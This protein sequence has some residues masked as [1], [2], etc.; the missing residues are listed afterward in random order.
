[1]L[2]HE[3]LEQ[4]NFSKTEQTV[5]AF[6][7][8]HEDDL[9]HFTTTK[10]AAATFTTPSILVRIAQKLD[11]SGFR[12]FKQA[13]L[14]ERDYLRHDFGPLDANFP[15]DRQ[16]DLMTVAT[17]IAALK[18]ASLQDTLTL[19]DHDS[20]R[21][22]LTILAQAQTIRVFAVADLTFA[23]ETFVYKMRR[24]GQPA[25][26]FTVS[27]TLYQE[28]LLTPRTD[29]ALCLSYSG[30]SSELLTAAQDLKRQQVPVIALTSIGA[31]QLAQLADVV[32]AVT[33][34]EYSYTKIG[35]F[36]SLTSLE[37]LLDILYSAYFNLNYQQHLQTKLTVARATERRELDNQIL[38]DPE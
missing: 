20:L 9:A 27:N 19:L 37:L 35:N 10:I 13:L 32:L 23:A 30:Q 17:K 16:D 26:T 25:E 29:C 15:F 8:A 1:M 33:T 28:A 2:L 24:I 12:D 36:S 5:V 6:L 7:L 38:R 21:R 11:F 22:A 14:E 34:R 31:N 18:Q 4:T 3:K